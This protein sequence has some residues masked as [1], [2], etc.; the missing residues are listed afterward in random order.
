MST[1]PER[2]ISGQGCISKENRVIITLGLRASASIR[3]V[4]NHIR[5]VPLPRLVQ[6]HFVIRFLYKKLRVSLLSTSQ[7]LDRDE[8]PIILFL[9]L[10][11]CL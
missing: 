6:V 9:A 8:S 10:S 3:S 2:E 5:S 11:S 7:W 1:R 4:K